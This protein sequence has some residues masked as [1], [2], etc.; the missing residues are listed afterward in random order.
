MTY[1]K[2]NSTEGICTLHYHN[3]ESELNEQVLTINEHMS[4]SNRFK[5]HIN[6]IMLILTNI[7]NSKINVALF[8]LYYVLLK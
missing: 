2:A 6:S 1:F 5:D 4:L 8:K 7:L 3:K